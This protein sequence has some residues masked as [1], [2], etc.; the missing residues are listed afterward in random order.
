MGVKHI[1]SSPKY[2][3]SNGQ[4][5]AQHNTLQKAIRIGLAEKKRF[6]NIHDCIN[7][8]MYDY[9]HLK[10]HSTTG[11]IPFEIKDCKDEEVIKKVLENINKKYSQFHKLDNNSFNKNYY[12]LLIENGN[13]NK[14]SN[15]IYPPKK[16]KNIKFTYSVP[17]EIISN[18][19]GGLIKIKVLINNDYYNKYEEYR[20]NYKLLSKCTEIVWKKLIDQN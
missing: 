1:N 11:F 8:C 16:K 20:V 5:E 10:A 4:I 13:V 17:V 3:Q 15:I 9:N 14:N 7:D 19:E 12:Y 2:P 6:F 18:D